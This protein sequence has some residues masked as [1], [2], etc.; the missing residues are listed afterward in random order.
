MRTFL[1]FVISLGA[2]I[3]EANLALFGQAPTPES[4]IHAQAKIYFTGGLFGYFRVPD[5]QKMEAAPGS[6]FYCPTS[7]NSTDPMASF[8]Q[9]AKEFLTHFPPPRAQDPAPVEPRD[10]LLLGTGDNF[11]PNYGA[12][13]FDSPSDAGD[14]H[15]EKELYNWDWEF[16]SW[17]YYLTTPKNSEVVAEAGQ[18]TIP[19]DNVG[20]FLSYAGYTAV[21]P[22][23]LDFRY[24]AERL[25]ELARFM[26]NINQPGFRPVQMLGSN[27]VVQTTWTTDHKPIPEALEPQLDY[28]SKLD[29][30][31]ID[32]DAS[33]SFDSVFFDKGY[34]YPWVRSIP[35]QTSSPDIGKIFS[36]FVCKADAKNPDKFLTLS[37]SACST[38]IALKKVETDVRMSQER[39]DKLGTNSSAQQAN[40]LAPT[41]KKYVAL[42]LPPNEKL[43]AGGSYAVCAFPS[44]RPDQRPYCM[45][46]AVYRPFFEFKLPDSNLT[47]P[48]FHPYSNPARYVVRQLPNGT[49]VAIFGLV[50]PGLSAHVGE[51]NLAWEDYNPHGKPV[52]KYTTQVIVADPERSLE[53]LDQAFEEENPEFAGIRVLLAQMSPAGARD[54][55]ARLPEHLRFDVVIAQADDVLTTPNENV[56]FNPISSDKGPSNGATNKRQTLIVVPPAHDK[57]VQGSANRAVLVRQLVVDTDVSPNDS[58]NVTVLPVQ[59]TFALTG[60]PEPV[61]V[62]K[63]K[64]QDETKVVVGGCMAFWNIVQ[65]AANDTFQS[66]KTLPG[67]AS[68]SP[69][70]HPGSSVA[71][72]DEQTFE[73]LVLEAMRKDAGADIAFLQRRD[74]YLPILQEFLMVQCGLVDDHQC[75]VNI[76]LHFQELMDRILWKGDFLETFSVK[77]SVL[78]SVYQQSKKFKEADDSCC[79]LVDETGRDLIYLGMTEDPASQQLMINKSPVD[80]NA[81]YTVASSDFIEPGD[82]GYADLAKPPLGN[83]PS[84]FLKDKRLYEIGSIACREILGRQAGADATCSTPIQPHSKPEGYYDALNDMQ[85]IDPR[86]GLTILKQLE[87]WSFLH[88]P[89]GQKTSKEK[90]TD[91]EWVQQQSRWELLFD[92]LSI[93]FNGVSHTGTEAE[94]A[95]TFGGVLDTAVTA[96]RSWAINV[97]E[98]GE[99]SVYTKRLDWFVAPTL[100]YSKQTISQVSGPASETQAA[101]NFTVDFGA[102]LHTRQTKT[103]PNLFWAAYG[104]FETPAGDPITTL[105]LG[106][107]AVAAP[108]TFLFSQGHTNLLLAR[109]GPRLQNRKSF[110]EIGLEGGKTLNSVQ[111]YKILNAATGSLIETCNE[112]SQSLQGCINTG[113]PIPAGTN[114]SIATTRVPL[115]RFGVYWQAGLTVPIQPNLSYNFSE[116]SDFFFLSS[117]DDSANTRYRHQL[118]QSL[119]F[120]VFQNLSFEPSLTLF[121]YEN[122][123]FYHRLFQQQYAVKIN[124]SFDWKNWHESKTQFQFK[125]VTPQQP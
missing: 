49:K 5:N 19:T 33:F 8:S 89:L 122:K 56:T 72:E 82:T 121:L 55:A 21:V 23:K 60:K 123:I 14:H 86:P 61:E 48:A 119:R 26:A 47:N 43:E 107:P 96:K 115:P 90:P 92:T 38:P 22:G 76:H 95:N 67:T 104:H 101:N 71:T 37:K 63:V 36:F 1:R 28:V 85:P 116:K 125:K 93:G 81:L 46:F 12:R 64:R 73:D 53:Q 120:Y 24:G 80:P 113:Q 112:G 83:T 17:K 106:A 7:A 98:H 6:A 11:G 34:V 103:L 59:S 50:D 29:P 52:G 75:K 62:E 31:P 94:L 69:P 79:E 35:I 77:G 110:I 65:Q 27:L 91:E 68:C 108:S 124:Y 15:R 40:L 84:P 66:S 10:F 118:D 41:N 4:T 16:N 88:Q 20:C 78:Q 57:T 18:G 39:V 70:E 9:D 114:I 117:G 25:R 51:A 109:V 42:K 32:K 3:L 100:A 45:K 13:V 102:Y 105:K 58:T 99:F 30:N 74:I 111:N 2:C 54:F 97:N 44:V 87:L